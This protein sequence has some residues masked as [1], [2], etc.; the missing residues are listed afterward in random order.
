MISDSDYCYRLAEVP[1]TDQEAVSS[2]D[3]RKWQ[4]PMEEEIS[5][6]KENEPFE[7]TTVPDDR[8]VVGVRWVHTVQSNPNGQKYKA[9]I[10]AKGYNIDYKKTFA[11]TAKMTSIHA[12]CCPE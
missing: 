3:S 4:T 8:S 1:V 10:V 11:P 7:L 6:L 9:R 2:P 12:A 5:A